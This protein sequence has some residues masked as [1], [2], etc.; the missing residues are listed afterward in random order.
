VVKAYEANPDLWD[1]SVDRGAKLG[2][3]P[4]VKPFRDSFEADVKALA[5]LYMDKNNGAVDAEA[6]RLNLG[7]L[8]D[9]FQ[10]GGAPPIADTPKVIE[11]QQLARE[12]QR[13][14]DA[15]AGL[16]EIPVGMMNDPDDS[17]GG[18]PGGI[19]KFTPNNP[20]PK[21]PPA[22]QEKDFRPY[23]DVQRQWKAVTAG[24]SVL[25]SK[26]PALFAATQGSPGEAGKIAAMT[27]Q[28][29]TAKL[30]EVLGTVKSNIERVRPMLDSGQLDWRDLT[31]I[32]QQL[33]GGTPAK[34]GHPWGEKLPKS[35]AKD[36][37]GDYESTQ[38]W[39][40]LGLGTLA[41]AAFI[42][43][44][45]ATGGMATFLWAAAGTAASG[46]QA[47]ISIEKYET[48]AA[49]AGTATSEDTRLVSQEQVDEARV[50]AIMDTAFAFLDAYGAAK[51]VGKAIQAT[52]ARKGLE[53]LAKSGP[54]AA[55]AVQ[56]AVRELG[57][58]ETIRR[59]APRTVDELVELAGG[60]ASEAGKAL[61][62]A[63][64]DA[65]LAPQMAGVAG[66]AVAPTAAARKL[67]GAAHSVFERWASLSRIDRLRE[68]TKIVNE[69][70]VKI[71]CPPL[72][73]VV[74][75]EKGGGQ[76]TFQQWELAV[77]ANLL[78]KATVT[79]GEFAQLVNA[80]AHEG[81]HGKQWFQ[82]AQ[83]Q[84]AKTQDAAALARELSIPQEVAQAA[85]DVEAGRRPGVKL[86]AS[87]AEAEAK[88]FFESVYGAGK[89][90]RQK[91]LEELK[92]ATKAE[93]AALEAVA[94]RADLPDG[95]IAKDMARKQHDMAKARMNEV[96]P[97]YMKLPE[98]IPAHLVGNQASAA[99]M[100]RFAMLRQLQKAER[101]MDAA[102]K[103]F[104][105]ATTKAS[106]LIYH[107]ASKDA[108][109][110][111]RID[112][113]N[114]YNAFERAQKFVEACNAQ[115]ERTKLGGAP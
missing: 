98:E 39:I 113:S 51:G 8:N 74:R 105:E 95:H 103:V 70:L 94:L 106:S 32:H 57:A 12:I 27:P 4:S 76:L 93:Q 101:E 78:E 58:Q 22:G 20:P 40:A 59:A 63:A 52:A 29:A 21:P 34:S 50:A 61:R 91:I 15:I 16:M 48:L 26:N 28:E 3:I 24:R 42:F 107:E 66:H 38:F 41:A 102:Y 97:K 25:V 45:I 10:I 9:P 49:A 110:A 6:K 13:A 82:M 81:E 108:R 46:T 44:E 75:L 56:T 85:I 17:S 69:E 14:D 90:D 54:E 80:V 83:L 65:T 23:E 7:H 2:L 18:V 43:S 89:G 72:E 68:L 86:A 104:D 30:K 115:L 62:T 109:Y 5:A 84:A 111:A 33:W 55:Q 73:P 47:A 87:G 100:E 96:F 114:A 99:M 64:A 60:E 88:L 112:A 19:A 36:V 67:A 1:R 35:V 53:N 79:E 71:G 31:P 37:I 11:V 77:D 92:E